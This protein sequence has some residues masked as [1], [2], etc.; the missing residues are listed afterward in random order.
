MSSEPVTRSIAR[1]TTAVVLA[2]ALC[3]PGC[4]ARPRHT[5]VSTT[6]ALNN[7]T[8]VMR[9]RTESLLRIEEASG[10]TTIGRFV[11][12]G[13]HQLRS[14]TKDRW[15][16]PRT[17]IRQ[18]LETH[19]HKDYFVAKSTALGALAGGLVGGLVARKHRRL[20]AA[21]LATAVGLRF[22][23]YAAF[24]SLI[25]PDEEQDEVLVY[26]SDVPVSR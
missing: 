24:M 23:T 22:F 18:I 11:S 3:L 1:R 7:W 17:N 25:F 10:T 19:D 16:V 15:N 5:N 14:T 9:I 26:V 12:A 13:Q 20:W 4:A 21:V 2:C 8:A 6:S